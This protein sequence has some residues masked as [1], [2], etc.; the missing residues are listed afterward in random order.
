MLLYINLFIYDTKLDVNN[1][2]KTKTNSY[3]KLNVLFNNNKAVF[4]SY[5]N[6]MLLEK[7]NY[8]KSAS[9]TTSGN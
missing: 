1:F 8:K 5:I 3:K 7:K 6:V 4:F 9:F 2:K